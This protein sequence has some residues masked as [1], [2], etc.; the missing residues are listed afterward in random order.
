[1]KNRR[2]DESDRQV[3]DGWQRWREQREQ[4]NAT[5]TIYYHRRETEKQCTRQGRRTRDLK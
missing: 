3:G 4:R 5:E 2:E 1:M